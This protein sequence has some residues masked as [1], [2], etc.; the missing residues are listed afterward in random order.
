MTGDMRAIEERL[1][2]SGVRFTQ[3]RRQ[4]VEALHNAP[5][6]LTAAGLHQELNGEVPLSSTYRTLAVL[7]EAGVLASHPGADGLVRFELAEWISGHHH[8]LRCRS[9]GEVS[10]VEVDAAHEARLEAI[11]TEIATTAGFQEIGHAL[12]LV[13]VC[14]RCRT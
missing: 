7:G 12:D 11:A 4:V 3:A 8:H 1:R 14:I 2:Q 6:P 10:D 9:C 13:G 5:G